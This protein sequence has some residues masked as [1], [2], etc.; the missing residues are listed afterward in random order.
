[1]N[2]E[3]V[4][5]FQIPNL[6]PKIN[7]VSIGLNL[8]GDGT[9]RGNNWTKNEG[10]EAEK[11]AREASQ[12]TATSNTTTSSAQSAEIRAQV[13]QAIQ[14]GFAKARPQMGEIPKE[15]KMHIDT[16]SF[17]ARSGVANSAPSVIDL[18]TSSTLT[19]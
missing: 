11:L 15:H 19:L 2:K 4:N 12:P 14:E 5:L 18:V 10:E 17:N 8:E 7:Q 3:E 1:M 9:R 16:M 13:R 6:S